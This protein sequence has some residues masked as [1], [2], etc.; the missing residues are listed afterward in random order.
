[1]DQLSNSEYYDRI[2]TASIAAE[3]EYGTRWPYSLSHQQIEEHANTFWWWNKIPLY[4]YMLEDGY[5]EE[6]TRPG[7]VRTNGIGNTGLTY[8]VERRWIRGM[9]PPKRVVSSYRE[10]LENTHAAIDKMRKTLSSSFTII[11]SKTNVSYLE[12]I[13]SWLRW[14]IFG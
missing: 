3:I 11:E 7:I 1:M 10:F 2:I 6:T 14:I 13:V 5:W 8:N 9:G 4:P 12:I